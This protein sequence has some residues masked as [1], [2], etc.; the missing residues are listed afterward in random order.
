MES[1]TKIIKYSK[2]GHGLGTL[3]G[4]S[5]QVEVVGSVIGDTLLV[6]LGKKKKRT[7]TST[8]LKILNPSADRVPPLCQHVG[9]C[10]GCTWQQKSY[11]AQLATKQT[12]V[13]A[14]F[15]QEPLP[16][17]P[18]DEPWHYRN[19]MEFTFS[20][21]K[22]GERYLGLII[23]RSK[24]RVL[25]LEECHLTN[26]WF[27][28]VLKAVRTWWEGTN[29]KAY[30]AYTD[31]GTLRTLTLREGKSTGEKMVILT[32]SGNHDYCI[33]KTA[34]DSFK[35]AV[36]K[37]LPHENPSLFLRIH[38]IAKGKPSEFYEMHLGGPDLIHET[39]HVKEKALNFSIS[40]DS[41]FQ[42][43]PVQAEKLFTRALE[44]AAP[45]PT[46][47]VLDLYCGT[48][49]LGIVFAPYVKK[50]VGIELSPYAV[51]DAELNIAANN[52]TN[53][54]V[55][56]GDVGA[57]LSE[58]LAPPNL[59]II[60]PPRSGLTPTALTH[61]L[62]LAPQKIL[63][64]SCNPTTQS[65][66]ISTLLAQGYTLKTLQPVDQFPHTPHIENIAFLER[67]PL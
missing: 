5:A 41:F 31:T 45:K 32:I 21:N 7:F 24:G 9:S 4:R 46:D 20:Q 12:H 53:I 65:E 26:P 35:E 62:R 59:A 42:P 51:C 16:I 40:P 44:I 18:C 43:N 33:H 30:H 66:N 8:L 10:G 27:I 15:K 2:R 17:T 57:Y 55:H 63:Y 23:A 47:I 54:T 67:H 56:K 22:E 38:R 13:A 25:N 37:T 1:Q 28:D 19:K 36:Q 34:L 39:L 14:L 11:P 64:I 61:L 29:L 3:E 58:V 49:T 6:E 48:A 52:L 60:D 50:V